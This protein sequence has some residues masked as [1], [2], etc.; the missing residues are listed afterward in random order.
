MRTDTASDNEAPTIEIGD[1]DEGFSLA[2]KA[3][4]AGERVVTF[5]GS[6]LL[7]S[8][9]GE[10]LCA[11]V[12]PAPAE[13]RCE[14]EYEVLVENTRRALEGSKLAAL[15]PG[16]RRRWLVVAGTSAGKTEVWR[17]P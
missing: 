16:F 15:L 10:L 13:R 17:A 7:R 11:V 8:A 1:S 14:N 6:L 9:R 3:L 2:E 4:A 5:G 12:D